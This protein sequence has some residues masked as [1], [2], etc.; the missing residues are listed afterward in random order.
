MVPSPSLN[1]SLNPSI[2]KVEE[3]MPPNA[4]T[5]EN[6]LDTEPTETSMAEGRFGF[7]RR[8]DGYDRATSIDSVVDSDKDDKKIVSNRRWFS[9]SQSREEEVVVVEEEQQQ[10]EE[11]LKDEETSTP[12]PPATNPETR[13]EIPRFSRFRMSYWTSTDVENPEKDS[14]SN[15]ESTLT[16]AA[17]RK[18]QLESMVDSLDALAAALPPSSFAEN[19]DKSDTNFDV[20][21]QQSEIPGVEPI[22]STLTEESS[23]CTVPLKP[24]EIPV[25]QKRFRRF[26]MSY[27]SE[28][29]TPNT[30]GNS[31][32]Q[33]ALFCKEFQKEAGLDDEVLQHL[34]EFEKNYK[35]QQS[36]VK[37][38]LVKASSERKTQSG[39][40]RRDGNLI[41]RSFGDSRNITT[42]QAI[43]K[44]A[45]STAQLWDIMGRF[46]RPRLP[47]ETRTIEDG[48]KDKNA[49]LEIP[50][51]DSTED[52][53][54]WNRFR[55]WRNGRQEDSSTKEGEEQ[56]KKKAA[57]MVREGAG[58]VAAAVKKAGVAV[59]GGCMVVVG[60]PLLLFPGT[61]YSS[62]F[63]HFFNGEI[64]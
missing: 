31:N 56:E 1:D 23:V 2:M 24:E 36:L 13:T 44:R 64:F 52:P 53:Q 43:V 37:E 47:V 17:S 54:R 26:R 3:T 30:K 38:T 46:V 48:T 42:S 11:A 18:S 14:Y 21:P 28:S 55:N 35:K 19:P 12:V 6:E 15:E 27:W 45:R 5:V 4:L 8:K 50:E 40:F 25:E 62:F 7:F 16:R 29:N 49:P 51:G 41:Q 32:Y 20:S 60:V 57:V 39:W 34:D 58:N 33:D 22:E 10:V 9:R 61:S 63:C 59:S